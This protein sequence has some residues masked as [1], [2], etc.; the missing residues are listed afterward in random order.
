MAKK[1]KVEF[2]GTI[3]YTEKDLQRDLEIIEG[4]GFMISEEDM[5]AP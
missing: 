5:T 1:L 3:N 4:Q 2:S